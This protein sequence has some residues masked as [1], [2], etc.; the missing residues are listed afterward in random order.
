MP[1][2]TFYNLP[3]KRK[4]LIVNAALAEFSVKI[5]EQVKVV[6]ICRKLEIPRVTFYSYFSS[7]D[8]LFSHLF[9]VVD[10]S[11]EDATFTTEEVK[12][13]FNKHQS[14]YVKL[15][16]SDQGQRIIFESLKQCSAQEKIHYHILLSLTKQFQLNL[17]SQ[18]EFFEEYRSLI[19]LLPSHS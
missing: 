11:V 18:R 1:S 7:L 9:H 13:E 10:S 15:V 3:K 4:D 8:D 2:K 5:Y 6:D 19:Q 17:I 12:R 14:F 16:E